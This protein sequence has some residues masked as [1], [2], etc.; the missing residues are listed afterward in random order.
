M[1]RILIFELVI[2][3]WHIGN[4]G[5]HLPKNS[6][7]PAHA[8][9]RDVVIIGGGATGTYAAIRLQEDFNRS[10]VLIEREEALGGHT[11]TYYDPNTSSTIELG[12]IAFHDLPVVRKYFARFDIPL[13][14]LF[15]NSTMES[16]DFLNGRSVNLPERLQSNVEMFSAW[17]RQLQRFPN[18]DE[19]YHFPLPAP[20]DLQRPFEQF[21][22]L[23]NLTALI[24]FIWAIDQGIGD[25]LQ[26]PTLYVLKS[27]GPQ[28]LRSLTT[29][30]LAT[31]R[32]NNHEI[33]DQALMRLKKT[34]SVLV[35]S[36]ILSMAR[37]VSGPYG[38]AIVRTPSGERVVQAKQFLFTIP[39][40]RDTLT[41]FDL[42]SEEETLFSAFKYINYS[43]GLLRGGPIAYGVTLC[44][45][46]SDP[47]VYSLPRLP[48]IYTL[49]PTQK[50]SLLTGVKFGSNTTM[51]VE[52][53]KAEI[54]AESAK[55]L[56]DNSSLQLAAFA[57]HG[58][59]AL[60]VSSESIRDGFYQRLYGLQG[61]RRSFWTG[62]AWHTHD[63]S[64][65]WN[66]TDTILSR[67]QQDWTSSWS[68]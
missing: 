29:G 63:S 12:V 9:V 6:S 43:T 42:D 48:A 55:A 64:L 53:M 7:G 65:L 27:F 28:M 20:L 66:F 68:N 54:V 34:K 25:M 15:F 36:K 2:F 31:K 40:T 13:T 3:L 60:S 18:L 56:R 26:L 22:R 30:F 32:Q 16:Y 61:R 24:P 49:G 35:N 1:L 59:Y 14:K 52:Q 4:A 41:G 38:R 33:Y 62:A 19:G 17:S 5:A 39:P 37:D 58:P 21:A 46:G 44:N 10:V 57:N 23:Y 47:D 51:T 67:M 11:R 8:I 45:R 50:P